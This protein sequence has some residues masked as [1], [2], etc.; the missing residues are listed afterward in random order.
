MAA[1]QPVEKN[2]KTYLTSCRLRLYLYVKLR[3]S[4]YEIC[5]DIRLSQ[6]PIIA[7]QQISGKRPL[8]GRA[9]FGLVSNMAL[10]SDIHSVFCTVYL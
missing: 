8:F 6:Y 10:I 7:I 3:L 1:Q 9:G 5:H 2:Y 4:Q